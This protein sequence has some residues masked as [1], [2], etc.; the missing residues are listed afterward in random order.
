M[1]R[2][3]FENG[4]YHV[5]NRGF[6]KQIIF[7]NDADFERFYKII[8]KYSNLEKYKDIKIFSYSF[9]PNHFHFVISNPG[10]ELSSFIGNI[11]NSYAKYFNLKNNRKGQL[12]EGRFKAKLIKDDD[13][14][15]KCLA[16]VN[17]NPIKHKIVDNIDN[18][19]WTSYHQIDKSKI[20]KYKDLILDELEF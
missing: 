10:A 13:Y 15:E 16:Y 17:F 1:T 9:M 11:Q 14:L 7:K 8:I 4:Y 5:Y 12:F 18:Y 19:K 20:E 3:T 2:R 6:D